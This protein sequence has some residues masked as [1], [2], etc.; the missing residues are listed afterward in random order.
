[1]NYA[2]S[3]GTAMAGSDYTDTTGTLTFEVG[4]TSKTISVPINDDAVEDDG[5][6]LTL[7][8]SNPSGAFF[9]DGRA[10]GTIR[11]MEVATADRLVHFGAHFARRP[12]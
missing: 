9:G 7:I 1:M 4:D 12:D 11:N 10:I 3:D 2:T 8:L 5:E 6:T